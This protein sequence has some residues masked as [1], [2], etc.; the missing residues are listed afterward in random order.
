MISMN[1][2]HRFNGIATTYQDEPTIDWIALY[3]LY[4]TAELVELDPLGKERRSANFQNAGSHVT[5]SLG[6]VENK[7]GDKA[8]EGDQGE[9]DA[10]DP[11]PRQT[12]GLVA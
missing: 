4:I 10:S 5:A 8:T 1:G 7:S 6:F 12:L 11:N 9:Q 2:S 3:D